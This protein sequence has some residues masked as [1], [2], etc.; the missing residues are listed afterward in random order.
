M[1]KFILNYLFKTQVFLEFLIYK[2]ND[3]SKKT[4]IF[5]KKMKIFFTF[6]RKTAF[7]V[8]KRGFLNKNFFS[9]SKN[10]FIC[11]EKDNL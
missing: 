6:L 1:P 4:Q 9:M 8:A 2:Y 10:F 5:L 3:I 7:L 11:G